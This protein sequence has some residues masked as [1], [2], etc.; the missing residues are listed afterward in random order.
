[1]RNFKLTIEYDGTDFS[2]WQIQ[3]GQRTVQGELF[4][5]LESLTGESTPVHG[6][7]RTDAGVHAR[8][9]VANFQTDRNNLSVGNVLNGMNALIPKDVTILQV[10]EVDL[11]FH[12]R[13]SATGKLYEYLVQSSSAP[14]ALHRNRSYWFRWA[15]DL[16]LMQEAAAQFV[17]RHDFLSFQAAGSPRGTTVRTLRQLDILAH[18]DYITFSLVGDG[19]LYKMVRSLVGTLLEVGRGKMTPEEVAKILAARDRT[20]AG[21]TAPPHGLYLDRVFYV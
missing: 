6:A 1:M 15:L 16:D 11:S 17:G 3:K 20:L 18:D 2:G 7:G 21:P 10:E 4:R 19:F 9:Q 13:K 14:S 5:A 12:A 8:G